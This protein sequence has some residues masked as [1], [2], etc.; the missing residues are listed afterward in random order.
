MMPTLRTAGF[1]GAFLATGAIA[2]AQAPA[3]SASRPPIRALGAVAA[4]SKDPL[5]QV[6]NIR[7]LPGGKLLVN[8]VTARR[9]LLLDSTM[10]VIKVVA[11]TTPGNPNAY[12]QG[13]ASLIAFRG[14]STLFVDAQSLSM[15]V[16]DA[17]GEVGRVMSVPRA[18]DAM[19][20]AAGGMGAGAFYSNGHLVYR[21]MPGMRMQMLNGA[22]QMPSLPDTMAITR[23]N[24]QTRVVDTLGFVK[25]PR[26]N[27]NIQQS[28]DGKM[29]IS[30]EV[31]PLPMVDEW[32]VLPNGDVA[33]VRGRDYHVDWVSPDGSR[34]STPKMAFDWKRLTDEDKTKLV[35][36][37]KTILDN[38]A[39]ANP[40]NGQAMA[41]A[42]GAA[43]G[44]GGGGAGRP[45]VIMRFEAGGGAGGAPP[46]RAPQIQPPKIGVVAA[47]ELPDYQPPF[48][49]TSTRADADGNLWVLT[50]PTKPQPA[51]SVYDVISAKG[52]VTERVLVPEG[53]TVLGFGPGGVV[54]LARREGTA[55]NVVTHI[56]RASVR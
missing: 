20:L 3:P 18:Q 38:Q 39:A 25:I 27:T 31:N 36:S 14:D 49:A 6:A 56:E 52:E 29:T 16:I 26:T 43:M 44:G 19:M 12:G 55:P 45:Q 23:V 54:Y 30:I 42:F 34:R 9:V 1:T 15:L 5:G 10:A 47:S 11:D 24:L 40:N 22:P 13:F 53:R 8:D 32:A 51:G 28:D 50:I 7:A 35:D 48:F 41:A 4:S 46:T 33:F 21:G 37:V 2:H 17:N